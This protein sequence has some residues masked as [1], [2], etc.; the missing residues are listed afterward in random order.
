[1]SLNNDWRLAKRRVA[2][3]ADEIAK[4]TSWPVIAK[5]ASETL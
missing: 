2:H 5:M 4:V 1:M 3:P